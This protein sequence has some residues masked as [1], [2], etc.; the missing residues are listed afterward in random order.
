MKN[1]DAGIPASKN[2][3]DTQNVA[4]LFADFF[5]SVYV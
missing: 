4:Q 1:N 5:K 3:N 2:T